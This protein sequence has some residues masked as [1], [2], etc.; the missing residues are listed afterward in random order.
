MVL[1]VTTNLAFL[2][3]VID[4]ESFRSGA[5]HTRFLDEH[6]AALRPPRDGAAAGDGVPIEALIAAAATAAGAAPSAS[7]DGRPDD[8]ER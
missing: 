1:G 4:H 3:R 5:V 6:A 2:R 7:R 8:I